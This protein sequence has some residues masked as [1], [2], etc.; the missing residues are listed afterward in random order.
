VFDEADRDDLKTNVAS[1]NW[2]TSYKLFTEVFS[3]GSR[4]MTVHQAKGLEWKKVIV[5]LIPNKA[6]N[7]DNITLDVMFGEPCLLEEKP[8]QEFTRMYYVACSR[9]M[10]DLYIHLPSGFDQNIINNALN[11]KNVQYEFIM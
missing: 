1:L 8:E 10:E 9:A 11:G 4:Y 7:R 3:S 6:S 2:Q 5:S